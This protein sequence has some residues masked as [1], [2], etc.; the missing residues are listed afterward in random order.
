MFEAS[1]STPIIS[2]F[3]GE[4]ITLSVAGIGVGGIILVV[5]LAMQNQR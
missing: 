2:P 1:V 3:M 4:L 5:I